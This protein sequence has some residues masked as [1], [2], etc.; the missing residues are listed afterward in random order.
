MGEISLIL[1]YLF[2]FI[3]ARSGTDILHL[4]WCSSLTGFCY[5]SFIIF[6]ETLWFYFYG[7]ILF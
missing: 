6:L 4:S 7:F 3:V 1:E 2:H 5:L